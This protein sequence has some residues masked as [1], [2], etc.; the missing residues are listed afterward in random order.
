MSFVAADGSVLMSVWKFKAAAAKDNENNNMI[1]AKFI[2]NEPQKTCMVHM[3]LKKTYMV[4]GSRTIPIPSL[5]TQTSYFMLR[6]WRNLR[7]FGQNNWNWS[8]VGYSWQLIRALI[9]WKRH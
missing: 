2:I 7:P 3:S 8:F 6:L 4:H 1:D 9:Q 5:A